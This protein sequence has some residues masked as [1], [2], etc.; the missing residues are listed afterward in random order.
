MKIILF[1]IF[2]YSTTVLG[3]NFQDLEVP[4]ASFI[5]NVTPRN[6]NDDIDF[7]FEEDSCVCA[8][9]EIETFNPTIDIIDNQRK[10]MLAAAS[11]ALRHCRTPGG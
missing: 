2:T 4:L 9:E 11:A 5:K 1:F 3:C 7:Y 6:C 8:K 10:K